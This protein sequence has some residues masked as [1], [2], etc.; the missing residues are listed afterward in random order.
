MS[1]PNPDLQNL[2]TFLRLLAVREHDPRPEAHTP[3]FW[4]EQPDAVILSI[5]KNFSPSRLLS[6][7]HF[8]ATGSL[9]T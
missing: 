2:R 9:P 7:A 4:L 8:C 3:R 6:Y 5:Q 1:T